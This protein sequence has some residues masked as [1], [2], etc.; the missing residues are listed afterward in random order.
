MAADSAAAISHET[1]TL[2]RYVNMDDVL[3][4]FSASDKQLEYD[5]TIVDDE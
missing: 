3:T 4:G 1:A 2:L 5:E